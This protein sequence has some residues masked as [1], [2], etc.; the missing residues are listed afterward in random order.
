M[1]KHSN[2]S[3][4]AKEVHVHTQFR[5]MMI[6]YNSSISTFDVISFINPDHHLSKG[7]QWQRIAGVTL[8][9]PYHS[10]RCAY[11]NYYIY[12]RMDGRRDGCS[13]CQSGSITRWLSH[14]ILSRPVVGTEGID[15]L[16]KW[17]RDCESMSWRIIFIFTM[18]LWKLIGTDWWCYESSSSV[19]QSLA[20]HLIHPARLVL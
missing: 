17:K 16:Q 9:K 1:I 18:T 4:E 7:R 8:S 14:L 11:G 6:K 3:A 5:K 10:S 15:S 20:S 2:P 13:A 19:S 12:L